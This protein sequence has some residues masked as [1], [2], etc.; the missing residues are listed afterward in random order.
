MLIAL[1]AVLTAPAWG[2][3]T[4]P[5]STGI[6][7]PTQPESGPGGSAYLHGAVLKSSYGEGLEQYWI[8]RPADP[9]PSIP[10]PVVLFFHGWGETDPVAYGGWIDHLARSGAVVI[11]PIYQGGP[12]TSPDL[13]L[14]SALASI[15]DAFER[16]GER[17]NRLYV[18]SLGH[19]CGGLLAAKY[20]VAAAN[21]PTL[22]RPGAVMSVQPGRSSLF[23]LDHLDQMPADTLLLVVAGDRDPI[24]GDW[25]AKRIFRETTLIPRQN[26]RYLLLRSDTRGQPLLT[27][28]HLAPMALHLGYD[29]MII[30]RG[31]EQTLKQAR[32][33]KGLNFRA[34]VRY[35]DA[36]DFYQ[37]WR[38]FDM[39]WDRARD[40][41]P[42]LR[43][44]LGL[45]FTY[46]GLWS[47]GLP[48]LAPLVSDDPDA[49]PT[50]PNAGNA[51]ATADNWRGLL[52]GD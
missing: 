33:A 36:V 39:L 28:G 27:A 8:F 16:L 5:A 26:K 32:T 25:D 3:T 15:R 41:Q 22:P 38:P 42:E 23:S 1:L 29:D 4:A 7:A 30:P 18:A 34:W 14:P 45:D 10:P 48:V 12:L 11:F 24:V 46:V 20:A 52:H 17:A 51:D 31:R 35:A 43:H 49:L 9:E 6:T 40:P 19:S 37:L 13:F 47:D 50:P 21:D 44:L 2:Q